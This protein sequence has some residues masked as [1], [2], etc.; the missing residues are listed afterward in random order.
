MSVFKKFCFAVGVPCIFSYHVFK[1]DKK[2]QPIRSEQEEEIFNKKFPKLKSNELP[3][4]INTPG[5]VLSLASIT[6][7]VLLG[8]YYW[9]KFIV[10]NDFF[11][12]KIRARRI[13]LVTLGILTGLVIFDIGSWVYRLRAYGLKYSYGLSE[14]DKPQKF[15]RGKSD[16]EI[17]FYRVNQIVVPSVLVVSGYI[18]NFAPGLLLPVALWKGVWH[19]WLLYR[20]DDLMISFGVGKMNPFRLLEDKYGRQYALE[21]FCEERQI[22]VNENAEKLYL[23]EIATY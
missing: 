17:Q 21:R 9:S 4:T 19:F 16:S 2:I 13:P 10:N 3:G 7:P 14:N 18:F 23:I 12:D 20:R 5:G 6:V 1:G 8:T 11:I 15:G 22:P